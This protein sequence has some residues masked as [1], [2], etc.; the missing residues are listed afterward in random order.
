M[1][2]RRV[3]GQSRFDHGAQYFTARDHRFQRYVDS[4]LQQGVVARWPDQEKLVVLK[5][6]TIEKESS[7]QHRHVGTPTMNAIC[8]HLGGG[9]QIQKQTRVEKVQQHENHRLQLIDDS[10]KELGQY[11]RLVISAPAGQTA[12]LLAGL[13]PLAEVASS[14]DM[15]R[16]WAAM[17]SFDV[18]EKHD[19]AG[20]FVHDSFI[21]WIA[22]NDSKPGRPFGS[23]DF[24]I[25][26]D[27]EF[28]V[29]NWDLPNEQVAEKIVSEFWR[30]TGFAELP[31]AFT[32]AHRWK[33][34]RS[35][36]PLEAALGMER[37]FDS[38]HGIAI[39]GDW[40]R[41]D[42]VE[43]AFLSG[44]DAAGVILGSLMNR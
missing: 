29:E 14:I 24:V 28:A 12:E 39:C 19:W 27:H 31:P 42:R 9:L 43:G 23:A 40:L 1:A 11:D 16:C 17:V 8:K 35:T 22:R 10:G 34:A 4:W 6:G 30:V 20:A 13:S 18:F 41:G 7:P 25:H 32:T 15:C 38:A 36:A 3:D 44:M 37:R 21:V 33:F 2:T 5:D 26:T